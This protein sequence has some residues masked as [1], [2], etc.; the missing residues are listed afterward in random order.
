MPTTS[1]QS[2]DLLALAIAC[3]AFFKLGFRSDPPM[4]SLLSLSILG[5]QAT[6]IAV[7]FLMPVAFLARKGTRFHRALGRLLLHLSIVLL[8][9]ALLTLANPGFLA[10]WAENVA[11]HNWTR[12]LSVFGL[13]R[14]FLVWVATF[15]GYF[16][17]S[18][19]RVWPRWQSRHAVRRL[20]PGSLLDYALTALALGIGG[21]YG[22]VA[23]VQMIVSSDNYPRLVPMSLAL[24]GF[25][26]FDLVTYV[27]P[28]RSFTTAALTHGVRLYMAWWMLLV[29]MLIRRKEEVTAGVSTMTAFVGTGTVW[30][31]LVGLFLY[32]RWQVSRGPA[33]VVPAHPQGG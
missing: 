31:L 22:V 21:Y 17:F 24:L 6:A 5:H 12:F 4:Q 9:F 7:F 20:G 29:G 3:Y 18:A 13:G 26:V 25:A 16:Y 28:I 8:A 11:R 32:W 27:R 23:A 14:G 10:Y 30:V 15:Y 1:E 2:L 33:G 19:L